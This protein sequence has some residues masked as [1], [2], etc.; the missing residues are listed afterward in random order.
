MKVFFEF[1]L[2]DILD[3]KTIYM[4]CIEKLIGSETGAAERMR[5]LRS[6]NDKSLPIP[7]NVTHELQNDYIEIEKDIEIDI[8]KD[9]NK[10][11][12]K[13]LSDHFEIIYNRYPRKEGK[14]IAFRHYKATVKT[15]GDLRDINNALDNYI[16]HLQKNR[17][18]PGFIKMASTW[19]NN[20]KDWVDYKEASVPAVSP[21]S[22]ATK[23]IFEDKDAMEKVKNTDPAKVRE[24]LNKKGF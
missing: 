7:N 21:E 12:N 8:E 14:K 9:I 3:N 4:K 16:K 11:F 18:E 15:E 17:T 24:M 10:R 1:G 20:W 13:F 6:K 2:I 23:T 19:F 5:K 22:K